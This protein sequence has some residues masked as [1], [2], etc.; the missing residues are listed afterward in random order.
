MFVLFLNA[1]INDVKWRLK[2]VKET[3]PFVFFSSAFDLPG[4]ACDRGTVTEAFAP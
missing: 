2:D 4:F 1:A 3:N